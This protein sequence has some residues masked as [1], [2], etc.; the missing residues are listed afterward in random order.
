MG[1]D[2]LD[3]ISEEIISFNSYIIW[4][5]ENTQ[6]ERITVNLKSEM[7]GALKKK[8]NKTHSINSN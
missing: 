2:P 4:E 5:W 8:K 3:V 7:S 1:K 6:L